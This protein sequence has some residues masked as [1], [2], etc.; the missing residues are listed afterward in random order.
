M[1][2][3]LNSIPFNYNLLWFDLDC[4]VG[5]FLCLLLGSNDDHKRQ[6]TAHFRSIFCLILFFSC[7]IQNL[8][9]FFLWL[10]RVGS[11]PK[12]LKQH[13]QPLSLSAIPFHSVTSTNF[14]NIYTFGER[15]RKTYLSY[16]LLMLEIKRLFWIYM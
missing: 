5:C 8:F 13:N 14:W 2:F 16:I 9:S 7:D 3:N 15:E 1:K 11:S 10:N 4:L 12:R 6:T